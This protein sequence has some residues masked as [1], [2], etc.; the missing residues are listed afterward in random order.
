M[1]LCTLLL[2]AAMAAPASAQTFARRRVPAGE[3]TGLEMGIDGTLSA[4][5]GGR[6]RW[7]IT[8]Y[9][10]VRRRDLRPSGRSTVRVTSSHAP[11]APVAEVQTDPQGRAAIEL[12][13]PEDLE[14]SPHVM[15]E[16]V[17]PRNVRRVFEVDLALA[18]RYWPEL[19]V[20]RDAMPPEGSITAF[21]RVMDR[22][23][24]APASGHEVRV[25]AGGAPV[26]LRT[27]G[28]GVFSSVLPFRSHGAES[29]SVTAHTEDANATVG[30]RVERFAEQPLVIGARTARAVASPGE[31]LA[32]DV[33]VQTPD[34]APVSNAEVVWAQEDH[35]E[36]RR[37][38]RTD[39]E[40][41][42][43]ID[44]NMPRWIDAP[45]A[46]HAWSLRAVHPAHRAH[47]VDVRVRIAREAAFARFSIENGALVPG[48]EGR[49]RV[50]V[51]GPDGL[52]LADRPVTFDV[53][54]MGGMIQGRTDA[55]GIA[56][57]SG[58]VRDP[59]PGERCGG[60]TAAAADLTVGETTIPF[61]LE[62]D[63]DSTLVVRS[64]PFEASRRVRVE[65]LRRADVAR[66]PVVVTAL[67]F[68]NPLVPIAEVLIAPGANDAA[69]ELPEE[70]RGV[71]WLRARPI[72]EGARQVRGGGALIFAGAAPRAIDLSADADGARAGDD[73]TI[74]LFALE[75]ARADALIAAVRAHAGDFA[76]TFDGGRASLDAAAFAF[77][78]RVPLDEAVSAVLRDGE[79]VVLPIPSAPIEHGLLRDPWRT[80]ARFVRGRV[81]RLMRAIE[82]YVSDH[83]PGELD[84]V[85]VRAGQGWRFNTEIL[86]GAIPSAGLGGEG[87]A[88][89][90]GEPLDIDSLRAMDAA[91]SYDN[92]ARRITRERLWRVYRWLQTFVRELRLDRPWARRGDPS[93]FLVSLLD[94]GVEHEEMP[95]RRALFDAWGRPFAIVR[96]ASRFTLLDPIPGYSVASAGPDGR[97]G[98]GDDVNDPFARVL[99]SGGLYAEAV[100]EDALLARVNGV[101]LGRATV[102]SLGEVFEI[103]EP[104]AG[105]EQIADTGAEL[106][107]PLAAPEIA[108]LPVPAPPDPL[109]EVGPAGP[110]T[111]TLPRERRRYSAIAVRFADTF[112]SI[113]RAELV[114]GSPFAV[115]A[116]FPTALRPGDELSVPV[117]LV[118]LGEGS[119]PNV[120][121]EV[122]G[123]AVRASLEGERARLTALE[124]GVAIVRIA[125]SSNGRAIWTDETR[126]RVIPDGQLRARRSGALI[127]GQLVLDA[128]VPERPWRARAI[129][130]AP[131]SFDL[132]PMLA[133]M[134]EARPA[135]FAWAAAMRGE[136]IDPALLAEVRRTA[137]A[138]V[139]LESACA[140]SAWASAADR[141]APLATTAN[142]LPDR[143]PAALEERAA[144]LAALAPSAPGLPEAGIDGVSRAASALR[145]DGWRTLAASDDR[146][147]VMARMA[148]ALLL[149]DRRDAPGLALLARAREAIERDSDGRAWVRGDPEHAGDAWIGTLALAIAARQA[150]EDALAGEL[151]RSAATR[152]YFAARTGLEGLFWA[153][154][155]SVYGA[156]GVDGP[157][158]VVVNGTELPLATGLAEL[159]VD[160]ASVSIASSAPVLARV[161]SR[162]VATLRA[163]DGAPLRAH[164]EGDPGR[165]GDR[166]AL[167]LVVEAN[168][169]PIGAPIVEIALPAGASLDE[170]ARS[171]MGEHVRAIDGPDRAGVVRLSLAPLTEDGSH[172]VPLPWRWIAAGRMRGLSLTAYDGARPWAVATYEPR[173]WEIEDR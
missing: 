113:A 24:N 71:V 98:T 20:D 69:I 114:A 51:V 52:P 43:R 135:I 136:T 126:V 134:R 44:W 163:S 22:A 41:R 120:T 10:V 97:F 144:I 47:A 131:R 153:V 167:E 118:R 27:D 106:P 58:T 2:I 161:E 53:P 143:L 157:S 145:Q 168:G 48:L 57:F 148:A 28:A 35:D 17:S 55:E 138:H 13:I 74:A 85:A 30:V 39:R 76:A 123:D 18:P 8:L 81:G 93:L 5:P 170:S 50:R 112:P 92:V 14:S 149:I 9:E 137:G 88:A 78:R 102:S 1:R 7:F 154:A 128:A 158:A 86:E 12:A 46:E 99:P 56:T 75:P 108:P 119:A 162:F 19:Y 59:V 60:P 38:A 67:A 70:P 61:C 100:G 151:A 32:V 155:A 132:D 31:T 89:L 124:P 65:I 160:P 107:P 104:I 95:E 16:A 42:A 146:P 116:A 68:G 156:F 26:I 77:G 127:E 21:G 87:A 23:R 169:Q 34:G 110:R 6:V 165:V 142:A 11:G 96:G 166:S 29:V 36:E 15:L 171:A 141:D 111:W 140:V 54:R 62:V 121:I 79:L 37:R 82:Q 72:L 84:D 4:V 64:A 152:M 147:A 129:I 94:G 101:A 103:E 117:R 25:A 91:F 3:V 73:G 159:D 33:L 133:P 172:R 130:T 150:G 90:D 109:G 125:A 139:P 122:E 66:A 63:P 105:E 173:S 45:W 80:R 164:I 83:V 49:V 40:G 115:R